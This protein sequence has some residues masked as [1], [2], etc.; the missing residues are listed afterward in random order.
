MSLADILRQYR[1]RRSWSLGELHRRSG[2]SK[3]TLHSLEHGCS[4]PTLV[5]LQRLAGVY[6]VG[7]A[8]LLSDEVAVIPST[9]QLH[10]ALCDD[11]YREAGRACWG[12]RFERP[13][14]GAIYLCW[15]CAI[16]MHHRLHAHVNNYA[17]QFLFQHGQRYRPVEF[18]RYLEEAAQPVG[19]DT[20][21]Q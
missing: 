12:L 19:S 9:D 8:D 3:A 17:Y 20:E 14:G 16:W 13:E 1:E 4:S 5:T 7:V 10:C 2:V 6:G 11:L 15:E 21:K 18:S